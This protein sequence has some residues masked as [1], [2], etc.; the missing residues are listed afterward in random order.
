MVHFLNKIV[1]EEMK[2][3]NSIN[4]IEILVRFFE[5]RSI[6]ELMIQ[7]ERSC[8][9]ALAK[10]SKVKNN[11]AANLVYFWEG[12]EQLVEVSY[13]ILA[14]PSNQKKLKNLKKKTIPKAI[15]ISWRLSMAERKDPIEF[16]RSF[17]SIK[18]LPQW[19]QYLHH[20]MEASI[21]SFS[22]MEMIEPEHLISSFLHLEKLIEI[23]FLIA[24]SSGKLE[25]AAIHTKYY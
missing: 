18:N 7:L 24:L 13:L 16:L 1:L 15:H 22:V 8:T 3:I 9:V 6:S 12:I 14:I 19:K 10:D 21:S 20:W 11:E 4:P 17:F 2:E 5:A 25:P 23:S